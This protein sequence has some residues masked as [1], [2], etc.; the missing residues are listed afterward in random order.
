MPVASSYPG[1]TTEGVIGQFYKRYEE[2]SKSA[3]INNIA[4]PFTSTQEIETYKWLGATPG[5]REWV[6]PRIAKQL[7]E[8]G[9]TIQNKKWEDTLDISVDDLRRDKTGQIMI[10]VNEMARKAADHPWKLL[11]DQINAGTATT[12]GNAYDGT[13]FFSTTHSEGASGT[14]INNL[15]AAQVA[16]LNVTTTTAPTQVEAADALLGV[17][18]YMQGYLDDQG[19]PLNENATSFAVLCNNNLAGPFSAVVNSSTLSGASGVVRDNFIR[20]AYQIQLMPTPRYTSTSSFVVFRTD[21]EAKAM[22]WQQELAPQVTALAE[23]SD[24]EFQNDSH[25]FGL[26]AIYNVGY[27]LWQ[28]AALAT[29]S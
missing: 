9:L 10:R 29:F 8:N 25:Q 23:G 4:T 3:W 6:G 21:V 14:Q 22:I 28:Y 7:R 12:F 19:D 24:Y 16:A 5:V 26:K 27:G 20:G 11:I 13:T 17:I 2:L 15:A 1:I 18:N